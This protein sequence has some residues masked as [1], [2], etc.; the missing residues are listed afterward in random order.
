MYINQLAAKAIAWLMVFLQF[1]FP[2]MLSASP[3]IAATQE[4]QVVNSLSPAL[5]VPTTGYTLIGDD[6]LATVARKYGLSLDELKKLNHK[7]EKVQRENVQAGDAIEVPFLYHPA[8]KTAK[9]PDELPGAGLL[10]HSAQTL[11]SRSDNKVSDLGRTL[12]L[13]PLQSATQ[14]WLNQFGNAKVQLNVANNFS[15][16]GSAIDYLLPLYDSPANLFFTQLGFRHAESRNT[17]NIGLGY[18]TFTER[19]MLGANAFYDNDITGNNRR[20][21]IGVEAGMDYLTF[22]ANSY[23]RLS[24]WRQSRDVIDYNERPASG[25]DVR[26]KSYLPSYPQL[27]GSVMFEQYYGDEVGL[28]GRDSRQKNPSAITAGVNYTPVSLLTLGLEHKVGQAGKRDT[29]GK[30]N[31][32][33]RLG[34][35]WKDQISSSG[36][37]EKYLLSQMRNNH[38]DRNNAIVLEYQKQEMIKLALPTRVSGKG[39]LS[40]QITGTLPVLKYSLKNVVWNVSELPAGAVKGPASG[41]SLNF[42]FPAFNPAP[43]A[44]NTYRV[45]AVAEDVKGN[46]SNTAETL[47]VVD[48]QWAE[49]KNLVITRNNAL[50]NNLDVNTVAAIITDSLGNPVAGQPVTFSA[51]S[52]VK[53]SSS[54]AVSDSQGKAVINLSHIQAGDSTVTAKMGETTSA[55]KIT[56]VADSNTLALTLG[57]VTNQQAADGK[58]LNKVKAVA[59]DAN[60]NLLADQEV[61]FSLEPAVAGAGITTATQKVKTN[62]QG[63]AEATLTSTKAGAVTV[64]AVSGSASATVDTAFVADTSTARIETANLTVT[65]NNALANGVATN[66]VQAIV[67]DAGGNL[68][69]GQGVTFTAGNGAKVTAVIATSG[70]D[71]KATATLS[72]ATAGI[73][74]VTVTLNNKAS[75]TV[76]TTFVADASTLALTLGVV[77]NQQVADGRALNKVQA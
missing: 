10:S 66:A 13:P 77:A 39:S 60:G 36:G 11:A 21:G 74:K 33:Y 44:R 73:S 57:V 27:G 31:F 6:S 48:S 53:V 9:Q 12:A 40:G 42:T 17:L 58:A 2:V 52:G 61:S 25:F 71:G 16:K 43:G 68:L 15:L 45:T 75:A 23:I 34:V 28:F 5:P 7:N 50:A 70:A 20:Y 14:S 54:R 19:W 32:T 55:A 18:R 67:T 35:P 59:R 46:I 65:R 8:K 22:S 56:F 47:I 3:A 24:D 41:L 69:A 62:T 72:N 51:D 26:V 63:E 76:D 37:A 64:K 30:I 38:V 29:L 1:I 49:L 4:A